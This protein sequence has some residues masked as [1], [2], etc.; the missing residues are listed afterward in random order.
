MLNDQIK[1]PSAAVDPRRTLYKTLARVLLQ[2]A[3]L[4]CLW[5]RD[6]YLG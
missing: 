1:K 3:C 2:Y 4:D 5:D 6:Y